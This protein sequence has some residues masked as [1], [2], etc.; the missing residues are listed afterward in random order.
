MILYNSNEAY[1]LP[2]GLYLGLFNG[3]DNIDDELD[4]WGFNGPMI[5]PITA[6][7]TTYNSNVRVAFNS[8]AL[9][10]HFFP[11]EYDTPLMQACMENNWEGFIHWAFLSVKEDCIEYQGKYYGDWSVHL[12]T[13]IIQ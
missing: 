2:T 1:S 13:Q 3:R 4:D 9:I 5:G 6:C 10:T 7:H 8:P 11:E 12:H